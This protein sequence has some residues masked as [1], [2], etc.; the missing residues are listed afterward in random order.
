MTLRQC[1]FLLRSRDVVED[2]AAAAGVEVAAVVGGALD[3]EDVGG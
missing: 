1:G 2:G 3:A